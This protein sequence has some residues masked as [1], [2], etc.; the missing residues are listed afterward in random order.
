MVSSP[1]IL[2]GRNLGHNTRFHLLSHTED[3]ELEG[4]GACHYSEQTTHQEVADDRGDYR[5]KKGFW[6][7]IR[8]TKDDGT[9]DSPIFSIRPLFTALV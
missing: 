1:L 8:E 2:F 3:P 7:F 4:C 9:D 5:R 6:L